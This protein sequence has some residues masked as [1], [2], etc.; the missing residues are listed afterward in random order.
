M[1]ELVG[2][3][4]AHLLLRIA[5]VRRELDDGASLPRRHGPHAPLG[6]AR[7]PRRCSESLGPGAFDRLGEAPPDDGAV[8]V[9]EGVAEERAAP[10]REGARHVPRR[11]NREVR[12]IRHSPRR[13]SGGRRSGGPGR[14]IREVEE[15][16]FRR[17]CRFRRGGFGEVQD[18]VAVRRAFA[19]ARALPLLVTGREPAVLVVA[20]EV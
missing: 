7:D 6:H 20:R 9:G 5:D 16:R 15:D 2:E 11:R 8:V 19:G 3:R 14:R 17:R 13:F 4:V 10:P 18:R 12:R 1:A